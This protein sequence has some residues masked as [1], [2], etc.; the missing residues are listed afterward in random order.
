MLILEGVFLSLS[1]K[2]VLAVNIS[3][4]EGAGKIGTWQ[5]TLL[6]H[7]ELFC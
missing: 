5:R 2:H 3:L 1:S 7:D 6:Y 4:N